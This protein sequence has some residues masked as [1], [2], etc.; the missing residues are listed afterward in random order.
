M[1]KPTNSADCKL[2]AFTPQ[3]LSNMAWALAT[4]GYKDN[5]FLHKLLKDA[6]SKLSAF[7]PQDLANTIWAL[8]TFGYEDKDFVKKLIEAA[9]PKL[10]AFNPQE[11]ANIIWALA[12][13]GY[14]DK[15]FIKKFI[16]A[17]GPKLN[18][19]NPQG[20]A[21]TNWA[22][23]TFGYED[24]D[25]VKKLIEAAESKLSAF[26]P[27]GLANIIWAIATLNYFDGSS[28][29]KLLLR[30][31]ES[32]LSAF[33]PQGLSK[34]AWALA[35]LD[36]SDAQL[37]LTSFLPL[38][39]KMAGRMEIEGKTQSLQ[40]LLFMEDGGHVTAEI[41]LDPQY[42]K[43]MRMCQEAHETQRITDQASWTQLEISEA[44]RRLPGCSDSVSEY[45]TEDGFFRID[46][47]LKLNGQKLAI[48]VDGPYHFLSDGKT[49]NGR[50]ILRNRLLENRGW[51]VISISDMTEWVPLR[52]KQGQVSGGCE[53][54]REMLMSKLRPYLS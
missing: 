10:S 39:Y 12:I 35:V 41:K 14:E 50:T 7:N 51:K 5:E 18:A 29:I 21:N 46:I 43:F 36:H 23:A 32:K 20:L 2:S 34:T 6:E 22:L 44:V 38:A 17:A 48:E 30:E 24:K 3:A 9:E 8:A 25:F 47:A 4:L 26:K 19:F 31:A 15:A 37:F 13:F 42:V 40:Y 49:L 28:F 27:Q 52:G 11:L 16:E 53:Q 45:L 33:T 54:Q 1:A